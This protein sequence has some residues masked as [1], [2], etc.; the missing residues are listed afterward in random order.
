MTIPN[1]CG[2]RQILNHEPSWLR[3]KLFANLL[4]SNK[5]QQ[6]ISTLAE[7]SYSF[8]LQ[9][10]PHQYKQATEICQRNPAIPMILNRLGT[11]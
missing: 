2:I 6:G 8:Y 4:D 10:N 9:C 3:K 11:P 1:V 5:W 7:A